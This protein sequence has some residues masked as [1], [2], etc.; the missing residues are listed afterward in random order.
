MVGP[1]LTSAQQWTQSPPWNL[2]ANSGLEYHSQP[3]LRFTLYTHYC[4]S[5]VGGEFNNLAEW[6]TEYILLFNIRKTKELIINLEKRRRHKPLSTSMELR[7]SKWTIS[8]SWE[9]ASQRT[10]HG[11]L[12]FQPWLRKLRNGCIFFATE[13]ILTDSITKC[14]GSCTAQ[15]RRTLQWV[16]RTAQNITG[17]HLPSISDIGEVRCLRRGRR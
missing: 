7:W 14:H 3:P 1:Y 12:T 10:C 8:G 13:S 4:N 5:H 15:D 17:T 11:H 2:L 16:I 9:T 6:C